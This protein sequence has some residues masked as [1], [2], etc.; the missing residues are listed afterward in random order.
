VTVSVTGLSETFVAVNAREGFLT[1]V[2][3]KVISQVAEFRELVIAVLALEQLV[4][5]VGAL[6]P[7]EH[8]HEATSLL[9]L[10]L[11]ARLMLLDGAMR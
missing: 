4:D 6:V 11:L 10:L 7:D 9:S 3:S 2:S 5:A 1:G 8:L